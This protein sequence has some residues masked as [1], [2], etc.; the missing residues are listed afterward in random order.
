MLVTESKYSRIQLGR[1]WVSAVACWLALS[2]T[3]PVVVHAEGVGGAADASAAAGR[4]IVVKSALL[5]VVEQVAA[6]ARTAG[7]LA[8][9]NV[10]EGDV[11]AQGALLAQVD[12][13]EAKLI[14]QRAQIE[15]ELAADK[16]DNDVAVRAAS[17]ALQFARH[18]VDRLQRAAVELPGSISESELEE[19]RAKADKAELEVEHA[20]REH[21]QDAMSKRLKGAEQ[22][23]ALRAVKIHEIPAPVGGMVVEV[24]R[25]RGEWVEPGEDVLRIMRIDRIRAEG[26][27]AWEDAVRDLKGAAATIAVAIPGRED[28]TA[29][30]R[31]VFI[32]PEINPVDGRVRIRAEFKNPGSRLRPGMRATLTI[33]PRGASEGEQAGDQQ[34]PAAAVSGPLER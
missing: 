22:A 31:V 27:V 11:V 15:H 23:L 34:P 21:R 25:R 8:A 1:R 7:V 24:F 33:T 30:G 9:L 32:S 14:Q 2:T 10:N 28:V 26:L 16:A 29:R 4:R 19:F 18:E 5:R 12:D 6:P 3:P 20:K 17:R 13:A